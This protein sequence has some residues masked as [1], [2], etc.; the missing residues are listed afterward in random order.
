[1]YSFYLQIPLLYNLLLAVESS[2]CD[3]LLW[4]RLRLSRCSIALEV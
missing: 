3:Y 1:M 4:W 2:S